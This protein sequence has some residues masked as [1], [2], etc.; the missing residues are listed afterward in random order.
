MTRARIFP[1]ILAAGPS[2]GLDF[3]KAVA[4]F[5][6][7]TAVEIAVGNCAGLEKVTV[8]LGSEAGKVRKAVPAGVRV[9]VNRRWGSGQLS[10]LLAGLRGVPREAAFLIYPVDQPLIT[11]GLVR[12]LVGAFEGEMSK[13]RKG[14]ASATR[15]KKIVMP[16][17]RGKVGHPIVCAGEL[18]AELEGARNAREVVYRDESRILFLEVKTES[19]WRDF[20]SAETYRE[21][22]ALMG[23]KRKRKR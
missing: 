15:A 2:R 16:R 17:F 19:I 5:G 10:S 13:V 1:I 21:C 20:D 8:V 23:R 14:A 9:V 11:V 4:K 6:R 7:K 3:P 18:R 22:L 12:R